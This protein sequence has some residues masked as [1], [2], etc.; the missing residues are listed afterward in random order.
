M[1]KSSAELKGVAKNALR[2]RWRESILLNL[3]PSLLTMLTTIIIGL[4]M[5][6]FVAF[7]ASSFNEY[8]RTSG[9]ES[10]YISM[11]D[12]SYF[13]DVFDDLSDTSISVTFGGS[14]WPL[15]LSFLTIGISFT[16]LDIL[17]N[18]MRKI[19]PI[20]DA[21]QVFNGKDFVP[22]LLLQLV[23]GIFLWLWGFLFI[24]PGII[25]RYSYSQAKFIYKDISETK[26]TTSSPATVYI[27]ESRLL[28]DG[29]KGRLFW[30]DLS[31]AGWYL[32]S[33]L[34]FGLGY[35]ILNPYVNATKAAFYDDLAKNRYLGESPEVADW[36][37]F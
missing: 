14:L 13:S 36:T 27:T 26:G 35:V 30:I 33:I 25:K 6:A 11:D 20:P 1:Y 16:F 17:R 12:D 31:F 18:P 4:I 10:S 19:K 22:L 21:F 34:T 24:I 3:V 29:H 28:M 2:G 5:V 7:S 23:S 8:Q 32:L 37:D 9:E 15:V